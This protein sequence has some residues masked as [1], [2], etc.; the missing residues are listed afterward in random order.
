M[1]R[2]APVSGRGGI[3][4]DLF[5]TPRSRPEPHH[6]SVRARRSGAGPRR[7]RA[8]LTCSTE[9]G[10]LPVLLHRL[11]LPR[12]RKPIAGLL[13]RLAAARALSPRASSARVG[14]AWLMPSAVDQLAEAASL[15]GVR[16]GCEDPGIG[17][18]PRLAPGSRHVREP[19]R[20]QKAGSRRLT[21]QAGGAS[22]DGSRAL[23]ERR[24]AGPGH[25]LNQDLKGHGGRDGFLGQAPGA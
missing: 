11:A 17:P 21:D 8:G 14:I 6:R 23:V 1:T 13:I 4:R 24:C 7:V 2:P 15:G 5:G 10:P 3:N 22:S 18:A 19:S 12:G 16:G 9:R 20:N 25:R